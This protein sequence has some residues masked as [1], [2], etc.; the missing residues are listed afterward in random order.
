MVEVRGVSVRYGARTAVDDVSLEV[1]RGEIVAI[2]GPN[3]SGKSTLL[4]AI[5]RMRKPDG[6]LV[7]FD[8]Q[9]IW[10]TS[11]REYAR[12]VAFLPQAPEAPSDL[13]VE[14]L[15]WR[16]RF[17]HRGLLAAAT[18]GD[19]TAV[20]TAIEQC[21][22]EAL[23]GRPLATLSGGERQRA[24]IALALAQEPELLL[25][26]EPTTF[27][28][29]GHQQELLQL[30]CALNASRG[31]TIVMVMHDIAQ[32]AHCA[33]RLVAMQGGRLIV[34][35]TPAEVVT[36]ERI[37]VLF[38]ASV[39]VLRHPESGAPIVVPATFLRGD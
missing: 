15:A 35:G 9:D 31:L 17:P 18:K 8:G 30:L 38:G 2:I 27:L 6:G 28:D 10:R 29:I 12:R 13:T 3:G 22:L 1:R 34:D 24:W 16:G 20:E 37:G 14:E 7:R 4:R 33:H 25:L 23:R 36:A 21:G 19:R 39:T 11:S 26:D 32:A 5:G